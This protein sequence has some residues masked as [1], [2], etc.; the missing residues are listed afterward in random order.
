MT[1]ATFAK[2]G[3]QVTDSRM[4]PLPQLLAPPGDQQAPSLSSHGEGRDAWPRPVSAGR[5]PARQFGPARL[6]DGPALPGGKADRRGKWL[7]RLPDSHPAL[8]SWRPTGSHR[9]LCP[10]CPTCFPS[11]LRHEQKCEMAQKKWQES[12]LPELGAQCQQL[13]FHFS[14]SREFGSWEDLLNPSHG[15]SSNKLALGPEVVRAT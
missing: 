9:D 7:H 8:T 14:G 5:P 12:T 1:R 15:R 2:L 3:L 13:H 10:G 11:S 4:G 6:L